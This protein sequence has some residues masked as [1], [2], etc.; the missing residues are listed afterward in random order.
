M[1]P[2]KDGPQLR[3]AIAAPEVRVLNAGRFPGLGAGNVP[4]RHT[5]FVAGAARNAHHR[6]RFKVKRHRLLE[7]CY[8]LILGLCVH[9]SAETKAGL[10]VSWDLNPAFP[11]CDNL[12]AYRLRTL[13]KK[14][15]SVTFLGTPACRRRIEAGAT[16]I[17]E[18]GFSGTQS[19]GAYFAGEYPITT[20]IC[21]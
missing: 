21:F 8:L 19:I 5:G 16:F 1:G 20:I 12:Q 10:K 4:K 7:G 15:H 9:S 6:R 18:S 3:V 17:V 13:E 2:P 14:R 11:P